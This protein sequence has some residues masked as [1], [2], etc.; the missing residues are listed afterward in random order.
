MFMFLFLL[1]TF[2]AACSDALCLF[3]KKGDIRVLFV[4]V[5]LPLEP[6]LLRFDS[7]AMLG[8]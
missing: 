8:T 7:V 2:L 4:E 6:M 1:A 5:I 3:V